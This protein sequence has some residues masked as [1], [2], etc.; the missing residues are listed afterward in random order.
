MAIALFMLTERESRTLLQLLVSGVVFAV[1]N[2]LGN[3]GWTVF[4]LVLVAAGVAY[5]MLV[6]K[7]SYSGVPR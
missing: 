1:A 4:A 5:A 3:A 6:I 2:Q 7:S